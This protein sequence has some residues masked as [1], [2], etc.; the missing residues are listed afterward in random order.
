MIVLLI[1]FSACTNSPLP[2]SSTPEHPEATNQQSLNNVPTQHA[3]SF[4][5]WTTVKTPTCTEDGLKE[6]SCAC[7]ETETESIS[8]TGHNVVTDVGVEP[9]CTEAGKT[10]GSHCSVCGEILT[11]QSDIPANGHYPETD[12]AVEPTCT[13]AGKSEGS[14]CFVCGEILTPQSDIPAKGHTPVTDVAVEPTCTET[15]KTEG[16]HCS[17]CGEILTPQLDIPA[18]G[19]SFEAW[20]N[21]KTPTCTEEGKNERICASCGTKESKTVAAAGH[22]FVN[23]VCT[24]CG[25]IKGSE[26]LAFTKNG[27][28]Y[29]VSGIGSCKDNIIGIPE[30]HNGLPVTAIGD[31][32]FADQ[33]QIVKIYIPDSVTSIGSRAFYNTGITE[34]TIPA[35][36]TDISTQ[37]FYKS[38]NLKTVIYNSSY[39]PSDTSNQFL[40]NTSI[41][42]IVFGTRVPRYAAEYMGFKPNVKTVEIVGGNYID[43]NAFSGCTNLVSVRIGDTIDVIWPWAFSNCRSLSNLTIGNNVKSIFDEVFINCESL[44]NI[45]IPDNVEIIDNVVF[46]GCTNLTSVTIGKGVRK[47]GGGGLG[48]VFR[49]CTKIE[50]VYYTGTLESWCKIQFSGYESNPCHNGAPLYIGG[51]LLTNAVLPDTLTTIGAYA[52][53]GCTSLKSVTI[54]ASLTSIKYYAFGSCGN[55]ETVYFLGTEKQWNS[56]SFGAGN[57]FIKSANVICNYKP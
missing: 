48:Y 47:I 50:K 3:H 14:H 4:G 25:T 38:N 21:V 39:A 29:T 6:R 44:T 2:D 9:T 26:D 34:I 10:E 1:V 53:D 41:E 24:V 32:A 46:S 33:T 12:A 18:K 22:N 5:N 19:H 36:V 43:W 31:K 56:I 17:V 15:G 7:G 37:P 42:K 27:D 11:P 51:K 13:E 20:T 57:E 8:A 40:N 30:T 28:G 23:G 35:S 16:S 45:T 49:D 55:L 54:P 52:F